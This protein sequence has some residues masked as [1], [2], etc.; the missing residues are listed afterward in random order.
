LV[1]YLAKRCATPSVA[2]EVKHG[3]WAAD[4]YIWAYY[5]TSLFTKKAVPEAEGYVGSMENHCHVGMSKDPE[6][7][8]RDGPLQVRGIWCGCQSCVNYDFSQCLMKQEFGPM[9]FVHCKLAK[10]QQ[11]STT[12]S[13]ALEEYAGNLDVGQTRAVHASRSEWDIEGPYWLVQVLG[14]AYQTSE[15]T[16]I[17]GQSI[18][19][20]Y[21][22][23]PAKWYKVVQTSQRAYVL[24]PERIELNVNA[25]VRLPDPVHFE[26]VMAR[27]KPPQASRTQP[28]RHAAPQAQTAPLLPTPVREK[29]NFL[30]EP[31]HNEVLA[32][33]AEVRL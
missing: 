15:D 16:V 18:P 7:T 5:D 31:K 21:W 13:V 11:V 26:P 29:L 19:A 25:M 12:R 17:S 27:K 2:K 1:V 30:G 33:L 32:S 23:V 14:K 24:Q 10:N 6:T 4:G 20:G 9:R 8:E 3:W 28:S 22:L